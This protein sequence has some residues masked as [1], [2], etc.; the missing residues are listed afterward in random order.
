MKQIIEAKPDAGTM[1]TPADQKPNARREELHRDTPSVRI[2]RTEADTIVI[3][4]G[5]NVY[6][7]PI[8]IPGHVVHTCLAA[9]YNLMS[10]AHEQRMWLQEQRKAEKHAEDI[11]LLRYVQEIASVL[12]H[13]HEPG[14]VEIQDVV[15][16]VQQRMK[17][18]RIPVTEELFRQALQASEG[19]LKQN[20]LEVAMD[21]RE[22][23]RHRWLRHT[24]LRHFGYGAPPS[25]LP[26][27][28][29]G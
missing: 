17:S 28:K 8:V 13:F 9:S 2:D 12:Y 10:R 5:G 7:E 24:L 25:L 15:D 20:G 29:K 16:A 18:A 1:L 11:A 26:E 27:Q 4:N 22:S 14:M 21:R 6:E 23:R 3:E 19:Y